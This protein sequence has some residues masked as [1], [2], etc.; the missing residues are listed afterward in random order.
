VPGAADPAGEAAVF[1]DAAAEADAV[2]PDADPDDEL[3]PELQP[4]ASRAA[5]S[6]AITASLPLLAFTVVS[7]ARSLPASLY[8]LPKNSY[9]QGKEFN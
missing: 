8:R 1:P 6:A 9:L 3:P 2:L 7:P 5:A 4:A